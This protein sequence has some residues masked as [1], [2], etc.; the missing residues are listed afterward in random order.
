LEL[1]AVIE[2][3]H[4]AS[5]RKLF[6]ANNR[7]LSD[8]KD[9][10][11]KQQKT[12]AFNAGSEQSSAAT[13]PETHIKTPA[14]T[15]R[16]SYSAMHMEIYTE[17]YRPLG[18][19]LPDGEKTNNKPGSDTKSANTS[20]KD[21][22]PL[23]D[24]KSVPVEKP[25]TKT[26]TDQQ[27]PPKQEPLSDSGKIM[28]EGNR[29]HI[30]YPGA[31]KTRDIVFDANG[32]AQE[33]ITKDQSGTMHLLRK[34]DHWVAQIQGLELQMPGKIEANDRGQVTFEMEQ[35]SFRR[36]NPDGSN[37]QE[38]TN[39]DGSRI[40]FYNNGQ[41]EDLIRKDGS[42]VHVS[43]D[44]KSILETLPN[45]NRKIQWTQSDDGSWKSDTETAQQRK[46]LKL[47][48]NGK[49]T[50]DGPDGLRFAVGGDG[51]MTI[52]GE[53][54]G[55]VQLD[56]QNRIKSIDYG[57]KIR[58]FEYFDK[59]SEIRTTTIKD[60]EK[61]SVNT[62]TREQAGSQNWTVNGKQNWTGDIKVGPDGVYSYKPG[63]SSM[64]E[65]DRDGRWST[66][67]ADGST[68][69]D[70]IAADGSRLSYDSAGKLRKA[71]SQDGTTADIN[72]NKIV[73]NNPRSGER[74]TWTKAGDSWQSDSPRFPGSKKDL[75]INEKCE[76][77]FSAE[78]GSKH[79]IRPD[80]KEIIIRKDGVKLEL[81]EKQQI[82]RITRGDA[83]RTIERGAD[84][85]IVRVS[86]KSKGSERIVVDREANDGISS[87]EINKD[88]EI[89]IK[90]E[91]GRS[92]LE[93]ADFSSVLRDADGSPLQVTTGKGD[94]RT[95]KWSTDGRNK[96]LSEISETR[97]SPKGEQTQSWVRKPAT[98][99]FACLDSKGREQI[100]PGVQLSE[101]G[102][103]DYTYRS[104]DGKKDVLARLGASDAGS[105]LSA[106]VEEAR[107]NLLDEMHDKLAEPNF[108]RMQE[109]MQKFESRMSD[110]DYLRKL[111]GVK[112]PEAIDEEVQKDVQGTYDNLRQMVQKGNE[113]TYFDQKTRVKLAENF[114]FQAMEPTTIDQGPASQ[115]DDV[116][117]GTCWIST[118]EIWGM[119]QHPGSM[120]DYLKQV[121]L[122]GQVTTKNSGEGNSKAQTYSFSRNL[123]SFQADKQESKWTI[124][125]ATT[126]WRDE[127]GMRQ[128]IIGDRSPVSK[129]FQKTLPMLS[130]SRREGDVDGGLYE[131]ADLVGQGHTRG[132]RDIMY[133]VTGDVPVDKG[134]AGYSDG[135]LLKN[136][137][138]FNLS[139]AEKGTVLNY[140]PG[141]LRSQTVR[142]V[143]DKWYLLQDD[144]HGEN[145]DKVL[146][147]ITDISRW[148]KG[149]RSVER[150]VNI[151]ALELLHRKKYVGSGNA[152][153]LGAVTP[154]QVAR[155]AAHSPQSQNMSQ[156]QSYRPISPAYLPPVEIYR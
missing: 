51:I 95:F 150:P 139:M 44:G 155:Q 75:Q 2:Q 70:T 16:D 88:G 13:K 126:M 3:F 28:R 151:S 110:R 137:T 19:S 87:V 128:Q 94:I 82:D 23:A 41:V 125:E 1:L 77:S 61:N 130:G 140:A 63:G 129:I 15:F 93:K 112:S 4:T 12:G 9:D 33:I 17:I 141:H 135:H 92:K 78:D 76:L 120:A 133:M 153:R 103:G 45:S 138:A 114:M 65:A 144:Q 7:D 132:V 117:H 31:G 10:K 27:V 43:Q 21:S 147:Q 5:K 20:E 52:Q 38:K 148:A 73:I 54:N 85:A 124:E 83:V 55:K 50:W 111:A 106:S 119:T 131:T 6:M 49:C 58:E 86:D 8:D 62:F 18:S 127:P 81:N 113:G 48:P 57:S 56:E 26:I 96:S 101:D 53:G 32:K 46:N 60:T 11:F 99:D 105:E 74:T 146:A 142:K 97:K 122:N 80:G 123:L 149:D 116:G 109:M 42:A 79:S 30:D 145:E 134:Q 84:G 68:T 100:R 64:Q 40:S 102:S 67:W 115:G 29:L 108:K 143:D 136:N 156:A 98:N 69:R 39:A 72:A 25:G 24:T 118:G 152:D 107:D 91:D 104:K 37:V 89:Q 66:M 121:C 47:E 14:E 35:G 22:K 36:E 34:G 154:R 71:L 90:A 59:S